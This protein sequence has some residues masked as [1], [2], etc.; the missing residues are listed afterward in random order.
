[1]RATLRTVTIHRAKFQLDEPNHGVMAAQGALVLYTNGL[2][3]YHDSTSWVPTRGLSAVDWIKLFQCR[4]PGDITEDQYGIVIGLTN[5][6]RVLDDTWT[7][8][9]VHEALMDFVKQFP[10]DYAVW[11]DGNSLQPLKKSRA[12]SRKQT[13]KRKL[14]I[15]AVEQNHVTSND[16]PRG[17]IST[18]RRHKLIK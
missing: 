13:H 10:Q 7:D 12:L 9:S 8:A 14:V 2:W 5:D 6:T 4:P 18:S 15:D 11:P 16:L 17:H 3:F 1:M